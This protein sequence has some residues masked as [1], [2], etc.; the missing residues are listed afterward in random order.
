MTTWRK[1]I[2]RCMLG[3]GETWADV[4]ACTLTDEELDL[5]F[6]PGYGG[7]NGLPFTLWTKGYVYFPVCYDGSEWCGSVSRNPGGKPNT[8]VGGG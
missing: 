3:T 8:H 5:E 6:D 2:T 7:E 1:D 4:E